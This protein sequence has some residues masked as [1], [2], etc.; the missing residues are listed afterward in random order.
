MKRGYFL[1]LLAAV[2]MFV[3]PGQVFGQLFVLGNFGIDAHTEGGSFRTVTKVSSKTVDVT[4]MMRSKENQ[5]GVALGAGAGYKISDLM[6]VGGILGY[7]NY[8]TF[9][10]ALN[11]DEAYENSSVNSTHLFTMIPFFRIAP[12]HAGSFSLYFEAQVPFGLG[13]TSWV[14]KGEGTT[15]KGDPYFTFVASP[16][17]LPGMS[18]SFTPHFAVFAN[19]NF[20]QIGYNF[21]MMTNTEEELGVTVKRTRKM[22]NFDFG[23]SLKRGASLGVSYTF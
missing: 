22:S 12:I 1:V 6:A 2:C 11:K 23:F 17:L 20:L 7:Q 4:D 16:R 10:Y 3:G 8:T 14:K 19:L 13:T 15:V 18:Y 9:G 5:L 21:T